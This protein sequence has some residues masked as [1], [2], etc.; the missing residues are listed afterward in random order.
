VSSAV[1][2]RDEIFC[3]QF[4]HDVSMGDLLARGN[5]DPT[6]PVDYNSVCTSTS[7]GSVAS[8]DGPLG[9]NAMF[10]IGSPSGMEVLA[11]AF[12]STLVHDG[13][14]TGFGEEWERAS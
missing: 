10:P 4:E 2:G 8:S 1:E 13:G 3:T 12:L 7:P 6:T 5:G 11:E 9:V 14:A